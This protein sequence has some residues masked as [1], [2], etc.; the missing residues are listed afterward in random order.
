MSDEKAR[1]EELRR[2]AEDVIREA[3]IE[4][5][6]YY[7][8]GDPSVKFDEG[9]VTK[10]ELRLVECFHGRVQ[11]R[12]PGHEIFGDAPVR[13]GYVHGQ[14]GFLWV[15]DAL[16]G[17]ANFQAGIPLWG[18]SLALLENFWP[19][20]GLFYMPVSGDLF[21]A[22]AGKKA[23]HRDREIEIPETGDVNNESLLFTYSRFHNH[24]RSRFPGKIRNLGCT[25]AHLCYVAMGRAEGALLSS[26]SYQDL[27]AAQIILNA[28]G[29]SIEKLGGGKFF[30][31]EHFEGRRIEEPLLAAPRPS[32]Q[33]IRNY[34]DL[35]GED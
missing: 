19:I 3:G 14:K 21:Y 11:E 30:L 8:R 26:V 12:F 17:V 16:D 13:E 2:F 7:G 4:A 5:L 31:N 33:N 20:F 34:L 10:A 9:L 22:E 24:Y 27:A 15:Y 1:L 35:L 25:A 28:A 18:I 32:H 29:G 6:R 23:Y